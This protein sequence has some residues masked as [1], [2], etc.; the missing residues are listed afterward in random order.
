MTKKQ[1]HILDNLS[2]NNCIVSDAIEELCTRQEYDKFKEDKTFRAAVKNLEKKR[3]DFVRKKQMELI[4]NGDSKLTL[5][6]IKELSKS[7]GDALGTIQRETMIYIIET[8][9]NNSLAIESFQKIFSCTKYKANQIFA[10]TLNQNDLESPTVKNKKRDENIEQSLFKRFERG[11]LDKI[12]MYKELMKN[13]LYMSEF[14][15]RDDVKI[16]AGKL[17]KDY[18]VHLVQE[19]ERVRRETESDDTPLV[20][21]LDAA[22]SGSTPLEVSTLKQ[23][24]IQGPMAIAEVADVES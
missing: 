19:Q 14:A 11:D 21:K 17:I 10:D 3:D 9:S 6:Y 13:A 16:A 1:Q 12:E 15:P 7:D 5:E 20:D 23:Q 18:D 22:I 2:L 8:A 4:D 24:F